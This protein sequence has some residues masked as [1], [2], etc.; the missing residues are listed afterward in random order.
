MSELS[1]AIFKLRD[2]GMSYRDI[3]KELGCSKSTIAY[4]LNDREKENTK[5]REKRRRKEKTLT[6]KVESFQANRKGQTNKAS[7]FHRGN[8]VGKYV[9]INFTYDDAI[10]YLNGNY[11]CYL[12]GDTIDLNDPKSYS[13]DHI[14]PFSKGG[15][16]ELHNLGLTTRAANMAKSDLSVEEFV[17]LCEKVARHHG[18]I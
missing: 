17:D 12:T 2:L 7:H 15:T 4:H 5:N 13:F 8:T 1:E 9:P 11:V 16:N 10:E 6:R 3:Q 18:R 14:V